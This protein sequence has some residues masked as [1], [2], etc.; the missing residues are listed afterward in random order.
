MTVYY[1]VEDDPDIRTSREVVPDETVEVYLELIPPRENFILDESKYES[2]YLRSFGFNF[3]DERDYF[4]ELAMYVPRENIH[5]TGFCKVSQNFKRFDEWERDEPF[6]DDSMWYYDSK[7]ASHLRYVHPYKG[8]FSTHASGVRKSLEKILE[9]D[10]R[11]VDVINEPG[12]LFL[13]D[14]WEDVD[15]QEKRRKRFEEK[16]SKVD[17]PRKTP[18]VDFENDPYQFLI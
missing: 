3:V 2:D 4:D 6:P 16:D 9:D 1:Q 15:I 18:P 12:E 7:V 13:P 5:I 10:F 17:S 11:A 14:A 8:L